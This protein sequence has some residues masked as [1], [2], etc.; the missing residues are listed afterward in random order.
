MPDKKHQTVVNVGNSKEP[1]SNLIYCALRLHWLFV[2]PASG[3]A[4]H[5]PV[6]F[7]FPKFPKTSHLVSGHIA[8]R[9]PL[10]DGIALDPKV[11][12][13]FFNRQ[14]SVLHRRGRRT[15]HLLVQ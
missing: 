4:P 2:L 15:V 6:N 10:V 5:P 8:A 7:F 9:N 1:L 12:S 13:Q 14:P 3:T 11:T